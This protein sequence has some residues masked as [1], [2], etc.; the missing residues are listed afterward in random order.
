MNYRF[1]SS[2]RSLYD[3]ISKQ[4]QM[5]YDETPLPNYSRLTV[6]HGCM[7]LQ[8]MMHKYKL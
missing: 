1:H 4:T 7:L 3:S 6:V 5:C 2:E 8:P